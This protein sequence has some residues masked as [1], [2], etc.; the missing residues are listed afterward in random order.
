MARETVNL[1]ER[2]RYFDNAL[3]KW[4][5][6]TKDNLISQLTE[7]EGEGKLEKSIRH[8]LKIKDGDLQKISFSFIDYGL[9]LEY[10]VGKDRKAGS[11]AAKSAEKP[12][13]RSVLP[14]AVSK[15]GEIIETEYADLAIEEI[16]AVLPNIDNTQDSLKRKRK[17]NG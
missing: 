17:I 12:W 7:R 16:L 4:A 1:V 15:L 6:F 9:Y 2:I 14:L 8:K 5:E 13:L 10:G 3:E 11:P